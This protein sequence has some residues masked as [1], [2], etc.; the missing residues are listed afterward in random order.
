M[1][2][3]HDVIRTTLR[4]AGLLDQMSDD[5]ATLPDPVDIDRDRVRLDELGLSRERLMDL[6]GA[7]P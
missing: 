4:R 3:S 7:S 1:Q 2:L 6:L 5:L